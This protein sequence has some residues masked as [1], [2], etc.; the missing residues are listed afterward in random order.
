MDVTAER[1]ARVYAQAFWG[2]ALKQADPAAA[3]DELRNVVTE[4]LDKFPGFEA[5]L[6]SAL[7]DPE[8]KE[9]AARPGVR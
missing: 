4:A 1:L 3:V 7:V 9:A 5:I 6:G 2:A 8:Q